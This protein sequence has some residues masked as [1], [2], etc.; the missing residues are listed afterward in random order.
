MKLI[1]L[2]WKGGFMFKKYLF[3]LIF[4]IAII[5]LSGCASLN[6]DVPF[7]Y[8]PSLVSYGKQI[9]KTVG[10]N[11]LED[12]RPEGD[13]AYTKSIKDVAEKVTSKL[14]E[15]L[16]KSKIFR[17]IHYPAQSDDDLTIDG[18]I[19]RFI[20]KFY[21]TPIS[22]IPGINLAIYFGAPCYDAYGIASIALEVKDNKTGNMLATI[23]ESSEIRDS[24]S[25]YNFK[26][27][28]AGAELSEAFRDVAKKLKTG[29]IT[30]ITQ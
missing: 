23:D 27:G 13:I 16:E 18:T 25:L 28:E 22:Y 26:A 19:N 9:E 17:E 15:D 24:Y 21:S 20:W 11:M 3:F 29:L 6:G 12:K 30:K 10:L 14:L 8:Q 4:G 5:I 2:Y 7:R 1:S